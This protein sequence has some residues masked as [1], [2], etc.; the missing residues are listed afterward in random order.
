M[1]IYLYIQEAIGQIP[2]EK[3]TVKTPGQHI[4]RLRKDMIDKCLGEGSQISNDDSHIRKTESSA[5]KESG[6]WLFQQKHWQLL[7]DKDNKDMGMG[8][9]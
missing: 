6:W 5:R 9:Q 2:V 7:V 8:K 3:K 4:C 1:H